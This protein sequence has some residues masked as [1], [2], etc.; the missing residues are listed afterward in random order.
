[1]KAPYVYSDL[2]I[3]E[4]TIQKAINVSDKVLP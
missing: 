3:L 1:M 4:I 2:I